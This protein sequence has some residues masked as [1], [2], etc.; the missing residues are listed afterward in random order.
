[1]NITSY[2]IMIHVINTVVF[3]AST[4]WGV[5]SPHGSSTSINTDAQYS[6]LIVLLFNFLPCLCSCI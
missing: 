1:M 6:F 3:L 5:M 4:F 2:I